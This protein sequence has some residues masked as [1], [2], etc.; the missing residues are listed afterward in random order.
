MPKIG[1]LGRPDDVGA[2]R[3]ADE[4]PVDDQGL[5]HDGERERGDG[6]ERAAQPQRQ[7]AGAEPDRGPT[8]CRR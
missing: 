6:E 5:Q 1:D 8:R 2:A 3:A 7:V 4:V